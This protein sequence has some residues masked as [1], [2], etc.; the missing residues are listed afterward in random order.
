MGGV[1]VI[2]LLWMVS[3]LSYFA[4]LILLPDVDFFRHPCSKPTEGPSLMLSFEE[5][6]TIVLMA[7]RRTQ[8]IVLGL[9]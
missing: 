6:L 4:F 1:H 3:F 9:A 8:F 2:C 7:Y 5:V